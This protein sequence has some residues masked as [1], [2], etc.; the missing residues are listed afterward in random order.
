MVPVRQKLGN[1]EKLIPLLDSASRSPSEQ[2]RVVVKLSGKIRIIPV[3]DI[4]Y[5]EAADDY[6]KIHTRE[7]CFLKNKTMGHFENSTEQQSIC[8]NPP[9]VYRKYY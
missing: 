4:H 6:V 2:H 3:E 1:K 9:V 8:Q 7:G 5:L